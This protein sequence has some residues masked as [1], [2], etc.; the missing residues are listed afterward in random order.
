M[1]RIEF[2]RACAVVVVM[3]GDYKND[4]KLNFSVSL[5]S[6]FAKAE[7]YNI[8]QSGEVKLD[9]PWWGNKTV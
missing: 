2:R 6:F 9:P 8:L 7:R 4:T 1:R 5:C 3:F